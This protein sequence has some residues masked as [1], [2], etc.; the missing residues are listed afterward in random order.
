MTEPVWTKRYKVACT[1]PSYVNENGGEHNEKLEFLG[2]SVL[3]LCVTELLVMDLPDFDEGQL[4]Q[5]R[6]ALVNNRVLAEIA[7]DIGLDQLL[8]VGRGVQ[9]IGEQMLAN[10]FEAMLGALYLDQGLSSCKLVV[11]SHL[12]HRFKEA[13]KIPAKRRLQE[14][15][16]KTYKN[17]PQYT[18]VDVSGPDHDRLYH[19]SVSI[20]NEIIAY[21]RA[22]KKQEATFAAAEN[23]VKALGLV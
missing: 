4:S 17:V 19:V 16:Q 14:W 6:H 1:H 21:G 2:D 11:A 20:N 23:A 22:S 12:K 15:T 10:C 18:V 5:A 8:R 9:S 3:Q 13:L 7:L